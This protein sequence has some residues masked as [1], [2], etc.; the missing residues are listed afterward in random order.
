MPV[1]DT[2]PPS[3]AENPTPFSETILRLGPLIAT[4]PPIALTPRPSLTLTVR[5]VDRFNVVEL[6]TRAVPL[7]V[8]IEFVPLRLMVPLFD[9]VKPSR[10]VECMLRPPSKLIVEPGLFTRL[11]PDA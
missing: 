7:V 4:T 10:M 1:T 6:R 8:E 2:V 3:M 11:I 5:S 9:A